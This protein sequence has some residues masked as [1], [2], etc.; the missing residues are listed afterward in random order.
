MWRGATTTMAERSRT[1]RLIYVASIWMT[2]LHC[3]NG[4]P[5]TQEK[6]NQLSEKRFVV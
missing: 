4:I 6:V 1:M 2:I 5:W 3:S